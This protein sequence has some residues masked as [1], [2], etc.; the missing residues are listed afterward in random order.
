MTSLA[1]KRKM[2]KA[3]PLNW[4][5]FRSV[6]PAFRS[7]WEGGWPRMELFLCELLSDASGNK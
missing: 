5:Q 4:M 1:H 2:W 6:Q 7:W 3:E